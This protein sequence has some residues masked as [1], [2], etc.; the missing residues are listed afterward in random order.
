MSANILE[1]AVLLNNVFRKIDIRRG[2]TYINDCVVL[3]DDIKKMN[4]I[5]N[6]FDT[7]LLHCSMEQLVELSA[8][9]KKVPTA[10]EVERWVARI[11][12][13]VE[14]FVAKQVNEYLELG[15]TT[16]ALELIKKREE[17]TL[18]LSSNIRN[19]IDISFSE[20]IYYRTGRILYT[21]TYLS[22]LVS[23]ALSRKKREEE[24]KEFYREFEEQRVAELKA[25]GEE[26]ECGVCMDERQ[27]YTIKCGHKLCIDCFQSVKSSICK[28]CPFCRKSFSIMKETRKNPMSWYG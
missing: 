16:L 7:D 18:Y 3:I 15:W 23:Y 26:V 1:H 25:K 28:K 17:Y 14:L 12:A 27:L 4:E 11:E 24:R 9:I 6:N 8:I 19:F 20:D 5:D 13:C 22:K 21:R 2:E 10:R